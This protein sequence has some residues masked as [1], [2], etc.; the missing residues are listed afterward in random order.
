[1][2]ILSCGDKMK[3]KILFIIMLFIV[4]PCSILFC[5]CEKSTPSAEH[6]PAEVWSSDE[7]KHWKECQNQRCIEIFEEGE[8]MWNTG[9]MCET[10]GVLKYTCIVC[11]CQKK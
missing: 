7:V 1:M 6:F 2:I 3:N 5:A 10:E 9:V 4:L 11:G 8:H